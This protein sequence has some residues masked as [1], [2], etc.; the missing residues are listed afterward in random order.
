VIVFADA[1]G[2]V[3]EAALGEA[4]LGS[5]GGKAPSDGANGP[6]CAGIS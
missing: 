2:K 4:E 5:V 3:D 6:A 1:V